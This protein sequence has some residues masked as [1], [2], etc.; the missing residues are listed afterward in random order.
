MEEKDAKAAGMTNDSLERIVRT[1][2]FKSIGDLHKEKILMWAKEKKVL[3]YGSEVQS[4]L[5]Y[6]SKF[7]T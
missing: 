2:S 7:C 5:S 1:S 6:E 4:P 3:V